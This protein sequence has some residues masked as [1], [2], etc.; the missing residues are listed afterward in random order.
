MQG[1]PLFS[2]NGLT[3]FFGWWVFRLGGY[4][5]LLGYKWASLWG[6][7]GP[8]EYPPLACWIA[9]AVLQVWWGWVVTQATLNG[10][11][12]LFKPPQEQAGQAGQCSIDSK[13]KA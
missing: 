5:S 8:R 3:V 2:L 9:G 12:A 13:K 6:V 7:V 1:N 11:L 10:L 4:T